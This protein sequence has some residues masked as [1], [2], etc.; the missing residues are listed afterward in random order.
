LAA[1]CRQQVTVQALTPLDRITPMGNAEHRHSPT[2]SGGI[3][4]AAY[5]IRLI[6]GCPCS[7]AHCLARTFTTAPPLT[8]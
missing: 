2:P 6:G 3:G 8:A 5:A 7:G 1:L 4:G